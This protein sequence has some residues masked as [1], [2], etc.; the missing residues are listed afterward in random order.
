MWEL[1]QWIAMAQFYSNQ[2]KS[3]QLFAGRNTIKNILFSAGSELLNNSGILNGN[4]LK[5]FNSGNKLLQQ[6]TIG[7]KGFIQ[8]SAKG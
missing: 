5:T 3:T 8:N 6:W 7:L 2:Q 4:Y 1:S